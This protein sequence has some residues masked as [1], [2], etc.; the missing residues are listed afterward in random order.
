GARSDQRHVVVLADALEHEKGRRAL[1]AIGDE[2][3][4]AGAHRVRLAGR[5]AHLFLRVAKEE[6][7]PSFQH[8]EGVLDIRVRVP[9]HLLG[10]GDLKLRDPEARPL[11]VARAP[12]D[13]VEMTRVLDR[14]HEW[15]SLRGMFADSRTG[16]CGMSPWGREAPRHLAVRTQGSYRPRDA[17]MD[18]GGVALVADWLHHPHSGS[19]GV[20]RG[21]AAVS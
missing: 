21:G 16:R 1:A 11:G 12:F 9:G 3:R 7:Q 15:P 6:A 20:R 13:L 5:Q 19:A 10:G 4:A 14:L 8:V 2:V 17:R 18:S